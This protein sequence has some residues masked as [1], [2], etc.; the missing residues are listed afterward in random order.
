M[1]VSDQNVAE[2]QARVATLEERLADARR[3]RDTLQAQLAE[4]DSAQRDLRLLL[5]SQQGLVDSGSRR[6]K[7]GSAGLLPGAGD[8][9]PREPTLAEWW[10]GIDRMR[11]LG[12]SLILSG[13]V[14]LLAALGLHVALGRH[15]VEP[16][17]PLGYI[18]G[19]L[20][21]VLFVLGVGL[22]F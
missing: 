21:L 13:A 4:A 18:F 3:E 12:A 22:I 17:L 10:Q 8:D 19:V 1:Q 5:L 6:A 7:P 15:L 11:R 2:L 16:N 20:A 14:S 9:Q